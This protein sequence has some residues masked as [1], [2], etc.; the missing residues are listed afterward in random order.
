M[1][2]FLKSGPCISVPAKYRPG[3]LADSPTGVRAGKRPSTI[4]SG[5][6]VSSKSE[7]SIRNPVAAITRS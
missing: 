2:D 7:V 6:Q 4:R 1:V 3:T 5:V